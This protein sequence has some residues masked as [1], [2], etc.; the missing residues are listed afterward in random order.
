MLIAPYKNEPFDL[1]DTDA[2]VADMR[3]ALDKVRTRFGETYP[4]IIN[5]ERV[6]T[7]DKLVSTN[8]SNPAEIV[9]YSAK[10]TQQHADAA[11]D[12]A[13]KAFESWK[14]WTQED[15]SRVML[16]AAAIM[17]R[18]KR[19]LE[20]WLVY[21]IGKN[22]VE[23]SAEV[24]EMIDFTEYYA[25]QALTHVGG[26]GSLIHY[27]GEEN[28]SF[29]IPLGAGVTISPWNFP[30][31]LMTGMTVGA[32]VVGNTV[33]CKPAEDTI[34]SLAKVFDIFEEAG[35][36]P[37]VVNYLPGSGR[38]VG[39]YLVAHPRTRFVNFTGSLATGAAINESAA[40][41]A[42]G[43]KWFKRVFLELGGKDG[44]LVDETANL[45]DA[46]TGVIQAAF[47]YSG[48]KCSACSRLI[49]VDS[50]YDA[51]IERV[52]ERTKKLVVDEAK[53][54][55]SLGP[56]CNEMQY[57]K[58]QSYIDVG[59]GEGKLLTGGKV[60]DAPGYL[61]EPTIFGDVS[62]TAR[63]AQE[64]VFGPFVAAIRVKDFAEGLQVANNTVYGLTG[65]L[66]SNDRER[67]EIA[68]REFHVGNLYF[69]RKC[70]GALVGIQPFG[71]FNL[72]GTDT[73]TG[74]PDYLLQFMQIK[75]V[76]ERL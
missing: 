4:L 8:P 11:L 65:A 69:N 51:L 14:R 24:A 26:L 22:Y 62:P 31:A 41:L 44:I 5:G 10:A 33:V 71:G 13:W 57:R 35:L 43:Q 59:R 19:E 36:P 6:M 42:P 21:E 76:A 72:T 23:A 2:A 64:E 38:D 15:R 27:P 49:V 53:N 68:R 39:S 30:M 67:I 52:I 47:G 37:G 16:K 9:G 46:A 18:R 12:A 20:A 29:Y 66:F 55:P 50:V 56:V 40:K 17:R 75:A 73:K 34:V 3:G 1:F 60:A 28:E 70:T 25:R 74:G 7:D 54:N 48:Q 32:I 61:I 58:V 45:D 63:I